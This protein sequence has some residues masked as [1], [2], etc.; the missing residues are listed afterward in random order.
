MKKACRWRN[1]SWERGTGKLLR[2][3]C[4]CKQGPQEGPCCTTVMFGQVD[5]RLRE[6]G[7]GVPGRCRTNADAF[8]LRSS[9]GGRNRV[10]GE[11]VVA[12]NECA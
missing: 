9:S 6:V 12:R 4:S 11:R 2:R 1:C 8:A 10:R 5:T 7:E 3:G